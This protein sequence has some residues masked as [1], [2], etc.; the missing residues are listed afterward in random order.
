MPR[1]TKVLVGNVRALREQKPEY[2]NPLL[3]QIES[4]GAQVLQLFD[5]FE[6]TNKKQFIQS[7]GV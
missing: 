6:E 2:V 1:E 3:E 4:I 5:N 7:L